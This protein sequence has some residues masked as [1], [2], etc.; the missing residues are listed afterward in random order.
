M[1]KRIFKFPIKFYRYWLSPL[2]G[3]N[4]RF[5]PTCSIYALQAIDRLPIYKAV[6][7][8]MFR[9]LRCHPFS[10]GGDDPVL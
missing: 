1:Y 7:K 8:I 4:C 9:I 10:K 5:S 6:P 2:I 3:Q